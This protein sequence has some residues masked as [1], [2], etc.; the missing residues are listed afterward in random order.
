VDRLFCA[1]YSERYTGKKGYSVYSVRSG[2]DLG[3]TIFATLNSCY[4]R[5]GR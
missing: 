5:L 4:S 2:K 3:T 1:P